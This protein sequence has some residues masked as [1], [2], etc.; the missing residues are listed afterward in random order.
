M[1]D[2][3]PDIKLRREGDCARYETYIVIADDKERL[4]GYAYKT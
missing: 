3:I 1:R 4:R 2:K